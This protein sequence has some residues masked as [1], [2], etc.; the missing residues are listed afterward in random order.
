MARTKAKTATRQQ[1]EEL[2]E[3]M[4]EV[5]ELTVPIKFG[6]K[7]P[8]DKLI[9][10]IMAEAEE[11]YT[12][13]FEENEDADRVIFTE[14]AADTMK[15]LGIVPKEPEDADDEEE[16][17]EPAPAP[18]KSKG[19]AKTKV[20][21][22]EEDNDEEDDEPEEDDDEE[23]EPEPPKRK[24]K[25][26]P[27]VAPVKSKGKAEKSVEKVYTRARAFVDALNEGAGS[28]QE[29]MERADELYVEKTGGE[30][31]LT[32]TEVTFRYTMPVLL[33]KG[34]VKKDDQGDY[35]WAK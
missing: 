9:E 10:L 32:V 8:D 5:M 33:I 13:D 28:K 6:K 4:N 22:P 25:S 26:A 16:E 18:V 31:N 14:D 34:F 20:V 19:K 3:E 2:A 27:A 7:T 30:S 15:I 23:D 24:P 29:L 35:S 21:E 1:L 11:V 12:T 17:D